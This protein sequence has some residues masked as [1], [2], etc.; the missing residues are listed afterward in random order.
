MT[1]TETHPLPGDLTPR[2]KLERAI[3]V[4]HAGEFGAVR[5]YAGQLAMMK[6]GP[7]KDKVAKMAEQEAHH[8]ETFEAL[9]TERRVRPTVLA[10]VWHVAGW[11]LGAATAAMGDKAAMACTVAVEEVIDEHYR[12]QAKQLNG[13]EPELC[14]TIEEFRAEEVEHKQMALDERAEEAPGYLL[15]R[16]GIGAGSRMAIWLS[17]RV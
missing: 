14:A 1:R 12:G 5:I 8:L 6:N 15:M 2:Q 7:A 16:L 13:T 11:A 4:D 10:P 3:R 9:M 17:E